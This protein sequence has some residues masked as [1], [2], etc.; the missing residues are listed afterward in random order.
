[1][2]DTS[3][4][5]VVGW[6]CHLKETTERD[7]RGMEVIGVH[8]F[9]VVTFTFCIFADYQRPA[10]AGDGGSIGAGRHCLALYMGVL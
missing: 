3:P 6:T 10:V 4:R 2:L 9:P 5:E 1:M 8:L 7:P